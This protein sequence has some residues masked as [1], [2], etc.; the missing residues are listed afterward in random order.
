MG[1][2][3]STTADRV[4]NFRFRNTELKA[5]R[6]TRPYLIWCCNHHSV[7]VLF[8]WSVFSVVDT[9]T[10]L[11]RGKKKWNQKHTSHLLPIKKA[12]HCWYISDTPSFTWSHNETFYLKNKFCKIITSHRDR[13]FCIHYF[14]IGCLRSD[15]SKQCWT[16]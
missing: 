6:K 12:L 15:M 4:M 14:S 7:C 2:Q 11:Q 13:F 8:V 1:C 9:D 16:W 5:D 10:K 3:S